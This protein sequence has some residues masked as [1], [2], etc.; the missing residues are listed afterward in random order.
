M[1]HTELQ[2]MRIGGDPRQFPDF[3]ALRTEISKQTHPARPDISWVRAEQLSLALFEK[4]GVELQTAAWYTLA[5]THLAQVKGMREGLNII[6][7][8][9]NQHWDR[10]WPQTSRARAEILCGLF[11]RLQKVFRTFTLCHEEGQQLGQLAS[12]LETL[13]G[14]LSRHDLQQVSQIASLLQQVRGALIRMES[15]PA[16]QPLYV[17]QQARATNLERGQETAPAPKRVGLFLSGMLTAFA[18]SAVGFAGW[19]YLARPDMLSA[20]PYEQTPSGLADE[21]LTGWHQG[22]LR[23]QSL[24]EQLNA[25]DG[26]KGKYLTVSELKSQVFAATLAFD[27]TVPVEEQLRLMAVQQTPGAIPEAQKRQAKQHLQQLIS[28]YFALTRGVMP[29][30]Q[31]SAAASRQGVSSG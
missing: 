4:N 26:Q 16:P 23:L 19:Y 29:R 21:S 15:A 8:M 12:T 7:V 14:I 11:Q 25:L 20:L 22:M 3:I 6:A 28:H 24:S 30:Q 10:F 5:R 13:D 2:P 27:K 17:I 18:L 31:Q 1:K 9:L